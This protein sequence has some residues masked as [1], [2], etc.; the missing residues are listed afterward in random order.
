MPSEGFLTLNR[1][2]GTLCERSSGTSVSAEPLTALTGRGDEGAGIDRLACWEPLICTLEGPGNALG[3]PEPRDRVRECACFDAG[4]C[5]IRRDL[6]S[7]GDPFTTCLPP[8]VFPFT[9]GRVGGCASGDA[10]S[11]FLEPL[12]P[13]Y[14]C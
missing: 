6:L 7:L 10:V 4:D 12:W 14:C 5:E 13:A 11:D 2:L 3:V 9:P 8:D 1:S